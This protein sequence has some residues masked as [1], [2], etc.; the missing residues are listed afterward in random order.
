MASEAPVVEVRGLHKTFRVGFFRKKVEAV[1]GIDFEVRRGEIFGLLGPNGA[2]KTTSIKS[3]LRLIFPTA[4]TIKLFG[5]LS[6]SPEALRRLGYLPES[7]Y[8]YQYLRAHE[9]LD[10]CGRLCGLD[11]RTRAERADE[12]IA[13]VGLGHAVDRPI[14]RFS[15][16]MLQR[17]GLAQALLH[18]PELLILDE[19]M[20][21]LDP[22][23]R[24]EVRDLIVEERQRGKTILFT[25]HILSDVERLCDRVAIVHRGKVTA[26]GALSQLLKPEVQRTEIE[27]EGCDETLRARL[28]EL[29]V[30]TSVVE[31]RVVAIV[32]GETGARDVL[33]VAL[34]GGARVVGV[35]EQRETLE[36]LFVR[37]ALRSGGAPLDR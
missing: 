3:I 15:K 25:S 16:G 37:D 7:P 28:D 30:K 29:G 10:L 20:S 23:G 5:S 26:Y 6:P 4:G 18:D 8:V 12:M 36:D 14:G 31:K 34:A 19:P 1:R 11:A 24:K 17:I 9:F 35:Q 2:G 21:G 33:E 32:E 13:R 27:L 22:I